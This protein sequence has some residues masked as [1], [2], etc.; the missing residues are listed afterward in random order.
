MSARIIDGKAHAAILRAALKAD[1]AALVTQGVHPGL[2]VIVVGDDPAS[3]TYVRN[4]A[5]ACEEAGVLSQIH[6]MPGNSPEAAIL[7][8]VHE[9]NS[10]PRIHGVL[11]QLPLPP[12]IEESRVL[13]A[14]VPGKDVD[15]F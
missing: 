14:V 11:V 12:H 8:K 13:A 15:G 2:A 7:R 4:K 3:R 1:A 9:L 6:Q 10:D 5:K